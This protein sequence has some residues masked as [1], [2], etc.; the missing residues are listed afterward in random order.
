MN[1]LKSKNRFH[2]SFIAKGLSVLAGA[3]IA[4]APLSANAEEITG[5]ALKVHMK[6]GSP[7][8]F[9][10]A[11]EPLITFDGAECH[12]NSVD[13][14]TKYNMAEIE[15][16][17]IVTH[18]A[19]VDEQLSNSLTVDLTNPDRITI[20]GMEADSKVTLVNLAGV[21]L[22]QTA[23]DSEGTAILPVNDLPGA[24]YIITSKETSFKYIKK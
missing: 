14:S 22:R 12:I 24:I 3:L 6:T 9:M 20:S 17:E 13:F 7:Q 2:A 10:L 19:S 16:A 8:F 18:T 5:K 4:L 11:H 15:F 21:V 1:N 23:A